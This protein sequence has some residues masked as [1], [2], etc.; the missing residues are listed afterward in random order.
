MWVNPGCFNQGPCKDFYIFS[1]P[2]TQDATVLPDPN[3]VSQVDRNG[4]GGSTKIVIIVVTL[5]IIVLMVDQLV[6]R[7]FHATAST[8][9]SS[10][11]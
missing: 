7:K 3:G 2:A 8:I 1:A 5:T 6:L 9:P 11:P 10:L 4:S